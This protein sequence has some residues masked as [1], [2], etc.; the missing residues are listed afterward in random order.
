MYAAAYP[1]ETFG[2]ELEADQQELEDLAV[3]IAEGRMKSAD[4]A[5][6]FERHSSEI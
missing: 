5:L 3:S 1:L 2:Y 4:I 6:W